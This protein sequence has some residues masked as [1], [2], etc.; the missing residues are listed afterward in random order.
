MSHW[1][2]HLQDFVYDIKYEKLINNPED[3]IKILLSKCDLTWNDS[4]VNF[5]KNKRLVKTSSDT[6]VRKKIYKSSINSWE[7][8]K[9]NLNVKFNEYKI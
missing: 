6:Q 3:E 2:L 9:K 5:Y 1:K 4:C 8:Y 7:N